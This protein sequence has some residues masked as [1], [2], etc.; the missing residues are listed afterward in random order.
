MTT[1]PGYTPKEVLTPFPPAVTEAA[2][3]ASE[4]SYSSDFII[5]N[6]L[7]L[8]AYLVDLVHHTNIFGPSVH[9]PYNPSLAT[10]YARLNEGYL[11]I[12][13]LTGIA[14]DAARQRKAL[15]VRLRDS[16]EQRPLEDFEDMYYAVLARMQDMLQTLNARLASGFNAVTDVLFV[17]GP[18]IADLYASLTAHWNI[19]NDVATVRAI[20][21]AVR[22]TRVNRLYSEINAELEA[23]VI[24]PADAEELLTDLFESKDTTE[25]VAWI[26]G[27]S[28]AMIGAWLEEKYRVLMQVE[29]EEDERQAREMRKRA[30]MAKVKAKKTTTRNRSPKKR[31][32]L[33]KLLEGASEGMARLQDRTGSLKREPGHHVTVEQPHGREAPQ[34]DKQIWD[35]HAME[36][37]RL[38]Q[39]QL[40]RDREWQLK[41]QRVSA[42]S[43]YLRN[44]ASRDARSIIDSS[45]YSY[46][47]RGS[48][49]GSLASGKVE[50]D[51]SMVDG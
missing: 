48:V 39:E 12:S 3:R 17:S 13:P 21:D 20:D 19:L 37:E 35:L 8:T 5:G 32:S 41:S 1:M 40:Q 7:T 16:I 36:K 49:S 24:T 11:A 46:S 29:K 28:P 30:K 44:A 42:Y 15:G 51:V 27:W 43:N 4:T 47:M 18:S 33:Q 6:L 2:V 34:V 50:E 10:L 14:K 38:R 25:G 23:N 9:S 31:S 22:Q 26:T 45:A